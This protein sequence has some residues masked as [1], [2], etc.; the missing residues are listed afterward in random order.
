MLSSNS[1]IIR[2]GLLAA[3][4]VFLVLGQRHVLQAGGGAPDCE[5]PENTFCSTDF[6]KCYCH[7]PNFFTHF[8]SAVSG[9]HAAG[10]EIVTILSENENLFVWEHINNGAIIQVGGQPRHTYAAWIR[11]VARHGQSR[12]LSWVSG[13]C[14]CILPNIGLCGPRRRRL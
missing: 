5:N 7:D 2:L 4:H 1:C 3:S 10:Y 14:G 13:E 9:C 12:T 11:L 6:A 8:E